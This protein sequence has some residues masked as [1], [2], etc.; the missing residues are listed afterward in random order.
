MAKHDDDPGEPIARDMYGSPLYLHQIL[1][2]FDGRIDYTTGLD[3]PPEKDTVTMR[4][5][6]GIGVLIGASLG[7][8]AVV[9]LV[10]LILFVGSHLNI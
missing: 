6:H 8:L 5:A 1:P 10:W 7:I 4:L 2:D 9:S 3:T